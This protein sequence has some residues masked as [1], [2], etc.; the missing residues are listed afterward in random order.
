MKPIQQCEQTGSDIARNGVIKTGCLCITVC[1]EIWF[2]RFLLNHLGLERF[3][4]MPLATNVTAF[5][6]ILS[7]VFINASGRFTAINYHQKNYEAANQAFNVSFFSLLFFCIIILLP[8]FALF[9]W[10][11]PA[12]FHLPPGSEPAVRFLFM[13]VLISFTISMIASALSI[14]TFIH[15]RLDISDM[16]NLFKIIL[17]RICAAGLIV[18][19][20]YDLYGIGNALLAA[21]LIV[22]FISMILFKKLLPEL[23]ISLG[24]W[25]R[26]LFYQ[27]NSFLG[28]AF[29]RQLCATGLV[30]LDI[31][32]VNRLYGSVQTG[33]FAV[34]VFFPVK[35]KLLTGSFSGLLNPVILKQ[36]ASKDYEG[37]LATTERSIRIIGIFFGLPVGLL[38]GL[39]NPLLRLWAGQGYESVCFTAVI[40]TCHVSLNTSCY[41]L[42]AIHNAANRMKLP[43]LAGMVFLVTYLLFAVTLGWPSLPFGINGI[44]LSG[45]LVLT[46]NHAVFSVYYTGRILNLSIKKL[47]LA[48]LPGLT[49]MA[50]TAVSAYGF[51]HHSLAGT[52]RGVAVITLVLTAGY[53]LFSW[54]LLI[55][56][57][58]RAMAANLIRPRIKHAH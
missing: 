31:I 12:L 10:S 9:A 17:S 20:G 27:I 8:L 30:Y 29:I 35:L 34:A 57:D 4:L 49:A 18:Y 54:L 16:T 2:A 26:T 43:A 45:T 39:Y 51:S 13:A 46:L 5:A 11:T 19:G 25:N 37:V 50:I 38:C 6:A 28:W 47:Y 21:S 32:I 55:N 41:P 53:A 24:L 33:L 14:G 44:A 56:P 42:F 3:G 23:R 52:A 1:I 15:N 7:T 40:L 22:L 36:Y 48:F 58:E